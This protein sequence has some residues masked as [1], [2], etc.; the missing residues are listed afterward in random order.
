MRQ[1]RCR[2]RSD[3]PHYTIVQRIPESARKC[4]LVR[5]RSNGGKPVSVLSHAAA[6]PIATCLRCGLQH[7]QNPIANH[8]HEVRIVHVSQKVVDLLLQIL[9]SPCMRV[10]HPRQRGTEAGLQQ[11][12]EFKPTNHI[13]EWHVEHSAECRHGGRFCGMLHGVQ[14]H[15]LPLGIEVKGELAIETA[16]QMNHQH[17]KHRAGSSL[18]LPHELVSSLLANEAAVLDHPQRSRVRISVD[19]HEPPLLIAG[20][21]RCRGC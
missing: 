19:D 4:K 15:H 14:E 17:H 20:R 10:D 16:L 21:G 8:G 11:L 9:G 1:H 6:L 12:W 18:A 13:D 2:Q 7:A 3:Q 5:S